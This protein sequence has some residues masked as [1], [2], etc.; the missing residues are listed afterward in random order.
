MNVYNDMHPQNTTRY[1]HHVFQHFSNII[2][3]HCTVKSVTRGAEKLL[4]R[5]LSVSRGLVSIEGLVSRRFS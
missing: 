2:R 3:L 5:R 4:L 1:L